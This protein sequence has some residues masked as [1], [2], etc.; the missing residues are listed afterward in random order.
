MCDMPPQAEPDMAP[1]VGVDL[2][3]KGQWSGSIGPSKTKE[4]LPEKLKML[5]NPHCYTSSKERADYSCPTRSVRFSP[6]VQIHPVLHRRDM[7]KDEIQR[8]WI[9]RY[10]RRQNRTV[11]ESTIFLMETGVGIHLSE[12]DYFC[13]RGLEHLWKKSTTTYDETNVKASH[14]IALAMQRIL[15][16]VGASNPDLIA[17]VYRKYT[18][19]SRTAAHKKALDDQVAAAVDRRS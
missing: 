2:P 3:E 8:V 9:N 13:P 16:R 12:D 5:I 14:K 11:V 18:L 19:K 4:L 6:H 7:S 15:R 1:L 10:E 17:K